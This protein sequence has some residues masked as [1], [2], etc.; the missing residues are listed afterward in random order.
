MPYF[1][2]LDSQNIYMYGKIGKKKKRTWYEDGI[3][4]SPSNFLFSKIEQFIIN[5]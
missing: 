1:L 2:T 3:V 5:L 4:Q